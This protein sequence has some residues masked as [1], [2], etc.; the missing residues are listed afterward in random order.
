MKTRV[1]RQAVTSDCLFTVLAGWCQ[2]GSGSTDRAIRLLSAFATGAG[3]K[4]L[5]PLFDV[6]LARGNRIEIVCGIDRNGTDAEAL[7]R[8]HGLQETHH[9]CM[10]VNIFNAPS[11]SAIFHPKLYINERGP[12]IDFVVGSA[13]MTCGG[14]GSNFE[15]LIL[16]EDVPRNSTVARH[17]LSIWKTFACPKSPLLAN[18]L[19]PLNRAECSRLLGRLP[20][21]SAWEKRSTGKEVMDMWRPLSRIR[22]PFSD[23]VQHRSP[24]KITALQGSYLLMDVLTE[25]RKTQMQIP[26]AIVQGFFGLDRHQRA[27]V[28]VAMW[29]QDGL[30][31]PSRRPIVISEGPDRSRLMRRI[32]VPQI[33]NL[34]RNLAIV[35]VRLRGRRRFACRI[36]PRETAEYRVANRVLM[37]HGQQGGG[38][39][40]YFMG[41]KGDAQ[42]SRVK[43]L[44]QI[45][46][47][48]R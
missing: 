24:P 11:K 33:R 23:C 44:L 9:S 19:K 5:S 29:S 31:Q 47:G 37:Q 48:N 2:S 35:F 32:E 4:A 14:L 16:Y 1:I 43:G 27:E 12:R 26:L 21:K 25:T 17:A 39:R 8:L 10:T 42:W 36:L 46:D 38:A 40:R 18:F 15:S 22:L 41:H 45:A 7:R 6:F 13:N 3:V 28:S 20:K 30:T 34:A